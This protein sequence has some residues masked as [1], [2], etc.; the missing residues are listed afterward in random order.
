M[1]WLDD[2]IYA[3]IILSSSVYLLTFLT[4]HQAANQGKVVDPNIKK[5]SVK[6]LPVSL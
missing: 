4:L 2:E 5:Y 3:F 6:V 1:F